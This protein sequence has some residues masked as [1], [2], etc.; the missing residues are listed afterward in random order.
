MSYKAIYQASRRNDIEN[1]YNEMMIKKDKN[2]MLNIIDAHVISCFEDIFNW[3][4]IVIH[5]DNK[6]LYINISSRIIRIV[7]DNITGDVKKTNVK[8]KKSNG[9]IDTLVFTI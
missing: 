8:Y 5:E 4:G 6:Y 1:R 9:R 3:K 7:K 2:N